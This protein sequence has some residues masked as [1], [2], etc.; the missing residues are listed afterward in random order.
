MQERTVH[1]SE[2]YQVQVL[3]QADLNGAGRL[4]GGQLMCWIDI[5]AAVVAR[6]HSGCNVTT[7]CVERLSFKKPAGA[8]DTLVLHG[9]M[10]Y[11]GRTSMMVRVRTYVET[12]SG[13][14]ELIYEAYVTM[15]ALDEQGVPTPV[16][17]L[18]LSTPE[19][20]DAHE[21]ALALRQQSKQ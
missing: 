16:P 11:A 8:N 17:K 14:R 2:T 13:Q 15:V 19:E 6:R 10:V 20:K 5:V 7:A 18:L 4:F 21:R 1:Y 12:L 3:T 9:A